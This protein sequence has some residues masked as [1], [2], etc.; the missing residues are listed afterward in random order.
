MGVRLPA[1]TVST[2][3]Y[4]T[5]IESLRKCVVNE[6]ILTLYPLSFSP[7][8]DAHGYIGGG[9][10]H[11][12]AGVQ[13]DRVPGGDQVLGE[14]DQGGVEEV[15]CEESY[16]VRREQGDHCKSLCHLCCVLHFPFRSFISSSALVVRP[17][18]WRGCLACI[19]L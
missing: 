1:H 15:W 3:Q 11:Q 2:R 18:Q 16:H 6:Q 9:G 14:R 4:S 12:C 13:Q 19:S 10:D 5:S 8:G 17:S 7:H